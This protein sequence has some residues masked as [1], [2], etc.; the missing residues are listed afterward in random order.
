MVDDP[1]ECSDEFPTASDQNAER[2]RLHEFIKRLIIWK[3]SNDENILA[4][5]RYEIAYS[6]ARNNGENLVDF[7]EKY[8]NDPKAVPTILK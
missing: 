8:E 7:R 3:N 4:E 1:S 2:N 6:V 5:A